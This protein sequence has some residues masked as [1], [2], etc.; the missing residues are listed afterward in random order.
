MSDTSWRMYVVAVLALTAACGASERHGSPDAGDSAAAGEGDRGGGGSGGGGGRAASGGGSGGGVAIGG[1]MTRGGASSGATGGSATR[2]GAGGQGGAATAG[3]S[4]G[5]AG[6]GGVGEMNGGGAGAESGG[7]LSAGGMAGA[8]AKETLTGCA[9]WTVERGDSTSTVELVDGG[10]VLKL[11]AGTFTNYGPF[12]FADIALSQ[13][14]LTGDFDVVISFDQLQPGDEIPLAGPRF[15]AGVW[16]HAESGDVTQANGRVGQEVATVSTVVWPVPHMGTGMTK[17]VDHLIPDDTWLIDA[18][19]RIELRREGTTITGTITVEGESVTYT[20][21]EVFDVDPL[22]LYLSLGNSDEE[23]S[24][25]EASV[26]ITS[27]MVEGEGVMSDTF[28]C[29]P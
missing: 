29:A 16:H 2:G 4:T 12:N 13:S 7:T 27:V 15:E 5:S 3:Q 22:E 23:R 24:T 9:T 26:R 8:P 6:A 17:S 18:S 21:D 10:V 20:S 1:S 25:A 28:D 14:G 11:P 19:G